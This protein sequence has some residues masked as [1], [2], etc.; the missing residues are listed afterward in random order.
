[1]LK[2]QPSSHVSKVVLGPDRLGMFD[3]NPNA[4]FNPLGCHV[5]FL[6]PC[7]KFISNL[8]IVIQQYFSLIQSDGWLK[9]YIH[10]F[11]CML[12]IL[13]SVYELFSFILM[14]FLKN[15]ILKQTLSHLGTT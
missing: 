8:Y 10:S 14:V 15:Y 11:A 4:P 6:N 3:P 1:M 2:H 12:V 9:I 5:T 7:V 13:L